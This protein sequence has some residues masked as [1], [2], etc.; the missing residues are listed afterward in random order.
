MKNTVKKLLIFFL[1]FLVSCATN[2]VTGRQELMLISENRELE[3]GKEAALSAN[4]E[5]GGQ[6]HDPALESYLYE[7]IKHIWQ[8][9][10]RP[11]LPFKFY[12]QN[13]SI[14][15]AF[16]LPGYVAITRGLLSNLENEAQFSYIM[17]HE[18]GHVMARHTAQRLSRVTLQQLGLSMGETLLGGTRNA[19]TLLTIGAIGS[20]FLLLKYDREQELAADRLGVRYTAMLGYNPNEALK[21]HEVLEKSLDN[22]LRRLG[23]SRYEDNFIS[24]LLSTHPRTDVRVSEIQAMINGLPPYRIRD[25]GKFSKRFQIE[26]RKIKEI[27]DIYFIYDEAE[28]YYK[29]ENFELAEQRLNKAIMLNDGQAPFYNLSGFIKLQKKNYAEA[30][31]LYEKALSIDPEYQP[32]IY[33]SGLVYYFRND[34]EQAINKFKKSLILYPD[35]LGAHIAIGKS[36]FLTQRYKQAIPH[37]E[38]FAGAVPSNPEVHG[39]LGICYEKT[40]NFELA[41]R[42]YRYQLKVAPDTETGI[43]ARKRLAVLEPALKR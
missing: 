38:N 11:Y 32:S 13:T 29:R 2:P 4:W 39:L 23:K 37:L 21:A 24:D 43:H 8:N 35:H 3:I 6:Y 1:F 34:Y 12:I 42:E 19:D 18:I 25:D 5:F 15:N 16:A 7:I 17:G 31:R 10:E 33:G 22:Y 40:G 30:E 20:S 28:N 36:Y 26:L 41:V 9:S 27:N 14:P